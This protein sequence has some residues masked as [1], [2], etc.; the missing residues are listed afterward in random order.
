MLL[1]LPLECSRHDAVGRSV[2]W[3]FSV[4]GVPGGDGGRGMEAG[5]DY[6]KAGGL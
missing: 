6:A 3:D 1:R 2:K 4:C 5:S